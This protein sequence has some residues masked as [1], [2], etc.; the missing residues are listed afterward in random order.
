MESEI[1]SIIVPTHNQASRL[2]MT[3][4]SIYHQ[5]EITN[6][7][8]EVVVVNDGSTDETAAVLEQFTELLPLKTIHQTNQGRAAARNA[9]IRASRG[10]LL[11]FTDSDRLASNYWVKNHVDFHRYTERTVGVGEI[12]E[13]YFS[14][15]ENRLQSLTETM[16]NNFASLSHLSRPFSYWEFIKKTLNE[17]GRC[18]IGAPWIMALSG[19]LSIKR[20]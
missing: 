3:L 1:T 13:F 2:E 16:K 6:S 8:L 15:L 17:Q 4:Q 5:Q 11:L 7:E 9:G 14:H 12:R 20:A 19:N 18:Q 10:S